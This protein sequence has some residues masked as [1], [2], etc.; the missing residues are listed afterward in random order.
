LRQILLNLRI[1]SSADEVPP[2]FGIELQLVLGQNGH[3]KTTIKRRAISEAALLD[4]A[5]NNLL[6]ALKQDMLKKDGR[7]DREKLRKEGYS[8]RLLARLDQA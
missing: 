7:M 8:D 2:K 3:V 1:N 6:R 5:T 4:H